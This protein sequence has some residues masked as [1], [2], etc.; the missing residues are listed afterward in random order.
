MTS[1]E[2]ETKM[3][4]NT[5]DGAV[6]LKRTSIDVKVPRESYVKWTSTRRK[7]TYNGTLYEIQELRAV[8]TSSRSSLYLFG[9]KYKFGAKASKIR[10]SNTFLKSVI[11]SVLGC[12]PTGAGELASVISIFQSCREFCDNLKGSTTVENIEVSYDNL[13]VAEYILDY[14]KIS[15]YPDEGH[16]ILCYVG[17][18]SDVT[19]AT[20][21]P[22]FEYRVKNDIAKGDIQQ[23]KYNLTVTSP[24]Y[25]NRNNTACKNYYDYSRKKSIKIHYNV[26]KVDIVGLKGKKLTLRIPKP[27]YGF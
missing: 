24:K 7:M 23:S 1:A 22:V 14:V 9:A 18:R 15:G 25:N 16:Q 27:N 11:P 21:I 12:T 19:V 17:N 10:A 6:I 26:Q 8:P 5:K 20:N 2:V 3:A 4:T 13:V